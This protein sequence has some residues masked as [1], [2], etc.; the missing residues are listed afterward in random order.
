MQWVATLSS[1]SYFFANRISECVHKTK[2]LAHFKLSNV[3][4]VTFL[5]KPS[6]N[7]IRRA[8]LVK[9]LNFIHI[10]IFFPEFSIAFAIWDQYGTGTFIG[11]CSRHHCH[12]IN[13]HQYYH[14]H[15]LVFY[16]THGLL[17]QIRERK[18]EREREKH[19]FYLCL[20]YAIFL[21]NA[22]MFKCFLAKRLYSTFHRHQF[23]SMYLIAS[24][25]GI[26]SLSVQNQKHIHTY[27]TR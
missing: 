16:F 13:L 22:K 12:Y 1:V 7:E 19:S 17:V 21:L 24:R 26:W 20:F 23:M 2:S 9:S 5:W 25:L 18:R 4:V 10:Y 27:W 3:T 14:I 6:E 8:F 15:R 11:K